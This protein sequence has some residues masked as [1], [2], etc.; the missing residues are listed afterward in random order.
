[1]NKAKLRF[2]MLNFTLDHHT[3]FRVTI[4]EQK[5][6]L[7]NAAVIYCLEGFFHAHFLLDHQKKKNLSENARILDQEEK[8]EQKCFYAWLQ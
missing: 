5:R 3:V 4:R 2:G 6:R 7:R 8:R 1:M